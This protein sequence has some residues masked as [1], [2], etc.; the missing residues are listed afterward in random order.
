MLTLSFLLAR[1][2]LWLAS[3]IA[4]VLL[5]GWGDIASTTV[6]LRCILLAL[7]SRRALGLAILVAVLLSVQVRV[8]WLYAVL[9][10]ISIYEAI[11]DLLN[12]VLLLEGSWRL[13]TIRLVISEEEVLA[14]TI[15]IISMHVH[16]THLLEVGLL[17][18]ALCVATEHGRVRDNLCINTSGALG[19]CPMTSIALHHLLLLDWLF[20]L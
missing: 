10:F 8:R 17:F 13:A 12:I 4:T 18:G 16:V 2:I 6:S 19:S 3:M 9:L 5:F 1:A 15:C 7:S 14:R 11:L 20:L